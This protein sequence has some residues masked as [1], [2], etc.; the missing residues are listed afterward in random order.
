MSIVSSYLRVECDHPKCPQDT[1]VLVKKLE[2]GEMTQSDVIRAVGR[3]NELGWE[4]WDDG[5][6]FCELHHRGSGGK[7]PSSPTM[8]NRGMTLHG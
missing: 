7:R 6:T 5:K 4:L 2:D 3:L 8:P 1:F